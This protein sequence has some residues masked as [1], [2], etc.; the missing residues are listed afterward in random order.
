MHISLNWI[1][2]FVDLPPVATKEEQKTVATRFT[3]ATAEVEE[4]ISSQEYLNRV[5]VAEITNIERHPGADKLNLVSFNYGPGKT[6]RVVCG[7]QNVKVGL[8]V[9]Y[10]PLNTTLPGNFTLTPKNI[11]GVVS[12]GMLCSGEELE[13]PSTVDG[14]LELDGKAIVGAP[15]A[16]YLGK[17]QDVILVVDNKSLTHRPDLWGHYGMA[18]EFAAAFLKPL[19][20]PFTDLWMTQIQKNIPSG[21][22][23]DNFVKVKVDSE[24][25]CLG[26]YGLTLKAV[27][28]GPSPKWMIERLES[29]GLRSI[30]NIVDISNYVMLEL[31]VPLHIFDR[32]KIIGNQVNIKRSGVNQK[33]KTLD[34]VER[35]LSSSDTVICDSEQSLVLA[36][37]M[38]GLNSGVDDSTNEIF[39]EVANWKA[40]EVRKT[41]V[42]L[43]LRTES[44]QRYEKSLDSALLKRTL[45]RTLELVLQLNPEAKVLAPIQYDGPELHKNKLLVIQ[46]SV[47]SIEK[48]LGVVVGEEKIVDIFRSLDFVVQKGAAGLEVTIPSYRATKDIG[49]E[50]DLVEEIGRIIG[51]DNIPAKAPLL[52]VAPARLTPMQAATRKIRD[53][54]V[55]SESCF[56]VMTYPMIGK[57]LLKKSFITEDC[58]ELVNALS[59]EHSLM[60]PNLLASLLEATSTNTK[61]YENGRLFELGR[62]YNK[63]Q[64]SKTFVSEKHVLGMVYFSKEKTPFLDLSNS[65]ERLLSNLNLA[66][67]FRQPNEKF[68]SSLLPTKWRGIHP[69]EHRDLMIMGKVMGTVISIHPLVLREF[70]IRCQVSMAFLDLGLFERELPKEKNKYKPLAKFP[71]STF[72]FTVTIEGEKEAGQ[73]LD[74]VNKLK[75]NEIVSVAIVDVYSQSPNVR[76]ITAR[77]EFLDREK[78]L[79]SKFLKMA[80]EKIVAELERNGF[81]L[82]K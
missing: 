78:T 73:I 23:S 60:R 44:S 62:I 38:G 59:Q 26:Y 2:D 25:S 57:D 80:E 11:R 49:C 37:I 41:S 77:V 32:K 22:V 10:A 4:V 27:K 56:E 17:K 30:N 36:G 9:P 13:I 63:G 35:E 81:P 70:K 24:S 61:N 14:L 29:V 58:L 19:K 7:A 15:M 79:T 8:K 55:L 48:Q 68:P 72:D 76:S 52:N 53:H 12:E 40:S 28:V 33:F 75:M 3:M 42:R 64:E 1:R 21:P 82:K 45:L 31:G 74:I 50:A 46:T 6:H 67:D 66:F 34:E 16:S 54:L 5:V 47:L 20:S 69:Y 39:I 18:R 65:L 43:G 71:D 51:Y